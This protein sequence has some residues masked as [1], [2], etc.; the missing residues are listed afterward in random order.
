M[1]LGFGAVEANC[2]CVCSVSQLDNQFVLCCFFFGG[3][4]YEC[5]RLYLCRVILCGTV[6]DENTK[7]FGKKRGGGTLCRPGAVVTFAQRA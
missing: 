4:F 6:I 3:L 2:M 1:F 7:R 5:L